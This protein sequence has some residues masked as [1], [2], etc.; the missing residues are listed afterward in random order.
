[1]N[2]NEQKVSR[3]AYANDMLRASYFWAVIYPSG[4][5]LREFN[6]HGEDIPFTQIKAAPPYV[7]IAKPFRP[8]SFPEVPFQ[9][10]TG[11]EPIWEHNVCWSVALNIQTEAI[12]FGRRRADGREEVCKIYHEGSTFVFDAVNGLEQARQHIHEPAIPK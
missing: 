2:I 1:M 7:I 11:M 6:V 9:I 12:I 4:I 5:E 3:E 8:S 10:E